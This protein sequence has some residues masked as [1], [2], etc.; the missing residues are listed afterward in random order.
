M[1][2]E[3]LIKIA[4]ILDV[5]EDSINALPEEIQNSMIS[6]VNLNNTNTEENAEILYNSLNNLWTKGMILETRL[7]VI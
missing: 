2:K 3:N 1:N 7:Y 4:K 5:S 6:A